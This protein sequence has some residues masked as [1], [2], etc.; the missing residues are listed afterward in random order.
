[1][2]SVEHLKKYQWKKGESGHPGREVGSRNK[3]GTAVADLFYRKWLDKGEAAVD[4]MILRSPTEFVKAA[5]AI[6]P[7]EVLVNAFNVNAN[8]SVFAQYNMS[9]PRDFAIA[10][11]ISQQ[12]LKRKAPQPVEIDNDPEVPVVEG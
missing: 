9:D 6:L 2:G 12:M 8:V 4:A 7:K 11:E 10:W 5:I 3:L 1:M